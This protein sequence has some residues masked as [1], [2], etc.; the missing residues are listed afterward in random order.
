SARVADFANLA[1]AY[2][3]K[4]SGETDD[5]NVAFDLWLTT[6]P[7]GPLS[8]AKFE[9]MIWVHSGALN[10]GQAHYAYSLTDS[11][12]RAKVYV[13]RDSGVS[14]EPG[15]PRWTY[16]ACLTDKDALSGTISISNII[17]SLIWNEVLSGDEYLSGI[18]FGPEISKGRGE[19]QIEKLDYAWQ[20]KEARVGSSANDVFDISR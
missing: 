5:F 4:I 13:K 8:T 6:G 1:V 12:L 16:I 10:P 18:E 2:S 19:L 9:L 17:K 11:D 14:S 15:A 20:T 3:V 7:N